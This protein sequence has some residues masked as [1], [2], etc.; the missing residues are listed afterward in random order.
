MFQANQVSGAIDARIRRFQTA[1][2]VRWTV[3]RWL[4]ILLTLL[5]PLIA[6]AGLS[7]GFIGAT[8]TSVF[9]EGPTPE[10]FLFPLLGYVAF[11]ILPAFLCLPLLLPWVLFWRAPRRIVVFRRFNVSS[12]RRLLRRMLRRNF[13]PFGHIFTLADK[14]IHVPWY[15]RIPLAIGQLSFL[16]FRP[17]LVDSPG[18]LKGL[19]RL[20]N[21][22]MWLNVNWFMSLHKMFPIRSSDDIWQECVHAL[23]GQADLAVVDISIPRETLDWEITECITRGLGEQML[24]L[25]SE[26][27]VEKSQRWLCE[28]ADK[29]PEVRNV[30]VFTYSGSGL[31]DENGLKTYAAAALARASAPRNDEKYA[32]LA[33]RVAGT[34]GLSIAAAVG[35]FLLTAPFL[36]GPLTAT[37]SPWQGPVLQ[38]YLYGNARDEALQRLKSDFPSTAIPKL[39]NYARSSSKFFRDKG[40]DGLAEIGDAQAIWPLTEVGESSL[41]ETQE[42]AASALRKV[43]ERLGSAGV[44][45]YLAA[46]KAAQRLP[47]DLGLYDLLED[48]FSAV[49]SNA[50]TVMLGSSS[51][52]ARFT[53]AF[54]LAAENDLRCVPIL[55]ETLRLEVAGPIATLGPVGVYTDSGHGIAPKAEG[56]LKQLMSQGSGKLD[57]ALLEAYLPGNDQATAY[58]SYFIVFGLPEV[59][60]IAR[61]RDLGPEQMR[62]L[63]PELAHLV[64]V[65][66]TAESARAATVLSALNIPWLHSM[67]KETDEEL[68]LDAALLLANRGDPSGLDLTLELLRIKEKCGWLSSWRLGSCY[69]FEKQGGAI[70]DQLAGTVVPGTTL[71]AEPPNFEELSVYALIK[72]GR[73]FVRAGEDALIRRLIEAYAIHNDAE[74]HSRWPMKSIA[75][76]LAILVPAR[77]TDWIIDKAMAEG[78]NREGAALKGL[79]EQMIRLKNN[80][81]AIMPDN[82]DLEELA[83]RCRQ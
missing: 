6:V 37:Y 46:L 79:A 80:C 63:L 68:Q 10:L 60:L 73:I 28:I 33:V 69:K 17:R 42:K 61:L 50:F 21:Q 52:A 72:L 12:E 8:L 26:A 66:G 81:G 9:R 20:L 78:D 41:P 76:E 75:R 15:V 14:N 30:P 24:F 27:T 65:P 74:R 23:L 64:S 13:A 45:E 34:Q 36:F 49:E 67:L 22:R 82:P 44:P 3:S 83:R 77:F 5:V 62:A 7:G 59:D 39:G 70:L 47:F 29:I 25:V 40:I 56:L 58:A 11:F 51:Q 32:G 1:M 31:A 71:F 43:M 16:N 18:G 53:A 48:E 54:R 38:A 19:R 35:G 57:S 4:F 55:L 2:R